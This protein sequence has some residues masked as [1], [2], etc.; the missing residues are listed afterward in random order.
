MVSDNDVDQNRSVDGGSW[1]EDG[2]ARRRAEWDHLFHAPLLYSCNH[3]MPTRRNYA[4]PCKVS[5]QKAVMLDSTL[6]LELDHL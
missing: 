2:G 5:E 6:E 3:W 4:L 1:G